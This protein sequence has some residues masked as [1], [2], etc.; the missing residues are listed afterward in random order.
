MEEREKMIREYFEA[1]LRNDSS[2]LSSVFAPNITYTECYG[3]VYTGIEQIKKWFQD[4]NRKGKVTAWDIKQFIHQG[5]T[6]AVEW[7]FE[8]IY[9]NNR[10]GFDGVSVITFDASGKIAA[11]KEFQSK[12]EHYQPYAD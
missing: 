6:T 3:P 1:W 7:Y 10:D 11:L 8:C 12:A 2:C 4:W 5:S 9:E